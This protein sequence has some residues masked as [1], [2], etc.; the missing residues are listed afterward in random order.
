MRHILGFL[1]QSEWILSLNIGN[2]MQ[3]TPIQLEDLASLRRNEQ[4]LDR[5]AFLETV[6]FLCVGYFCVSTEIR[7]IIQ[8]K[9]EISSFKEFDIS[10]KSNES[11]YWHTK[12]LEVACSFLP[13]DCPLLNHIL[14]SVV[15][16]TSTNAAF[17]LAIVPASGPIT[18]NKVTWLRKP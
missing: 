5:F 11:E 13:S 18:I 7:F 6:S 3:I 1:N 12:S 17:D 10:K 4:E 15:T 9:E 14:L 16:A 2:I 8:L